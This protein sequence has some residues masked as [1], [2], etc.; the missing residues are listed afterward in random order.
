MLAE[1]FWTG[2][3]RKNLRRYLERPRKTNWVTIA[4]RDSNGEHPVYND[5]N[6][7]AR[8]FKVL[9]CWMAPCLC[10]EVACWGG[11]ESV[12]NDRKSS[13]FISPW[14]CPAGIG[15][16]PCSDPGVPS[17]YVDSWLGEN[18]SPANSPLLYEYWILPR[19]PTVSPISSTENI[20][21]TDV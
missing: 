12:R 15:C 8:V 6:F 14:Q 3:G 16:T 7:S 20:R 18:I 21:S 17:G 19:M 2:L 5:D 10:C 13:V 9:Y 1:W 4:D 11:T